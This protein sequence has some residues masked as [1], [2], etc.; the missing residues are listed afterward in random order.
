MKNMV[1]IKILPCNFTTF[2][3]FKTW[4]VWVKNELN[5]PSLEDFERLIRCMILCFLTFPLFSQNVSPLSNQRI[6]TLRGTDDSSMLRNSSDSSVL[7]QD[8]FTI[9]P[10]SV[11]IIDLQSNTQLDSTYFTVKNNQILKTKLFTFHSALFTIKYR[12]FPLDVSKKQQRL[13]STHINPLAPTLVEYGISDTTNNTIFDKGLEYNGNYTQGLSLGNAQNLVVNQNFN[14]NLAGRLGDMDIL[15]AMTDNNLPIQAEGN[16]SELREIDKI[17]IQLKRKNHT[18]IAGDYELKRPENTYFT[19]YF[20]KLQGVNYLNTS[21]FNVKKSLTTFQTATLLSKAGV[22]IAKGKFSRNILPVQEGNQGP[23][24]LLGNEGSGYFVI[25]S[26]TEKVYF[27]GKILTRGDEY[28]YVIDYNRGDIQFT[29]KRLVTKDSRII[30]EFE[31]ADQTYLRSTAFVS[32]GFKINKLRLNFNFYSEQDSKNSTGTQALD[33][34]DRAVLRR[35]G[36]DVNSNPP[37]SIRPS[38]DGF[39]VDRIQYKLV[40]TLVNGVRF[41]DVLVFSTNADSA[42]Y[43]AS[44]TPVGEGKGNYIQAT[45]IANGR[46]YE[47]VSPDA[48]GK[49]RGSFE[50]LKKLTPPNK[51]QLLTLGADYQLFKNTN[52]FTEIALSNN[53]RNRFSKIGDSTNRG[54]AFFTHLTNRIDFGKK[55][56]W[57]LQSHLK[58]EWT[59]KDFKTLNPYRTAEFTRDWNIP[60]S[61]NT[62]NNTTIGNLTQTPSQ[63]SEQFINGTTELSR[64]NWFSMVYD[65]SRYVRTGQY[66]GVKNALKTH[67]QRK[68]WSI[69]GEINELNTEGRIEKTSFSRPRFD[70]HKTFKNNLKLGVSVEREKNKRFDAQAD[71]LTR[72]SFYDDLWKVYIEKTDSFGQFLGLNFLQRFDYQPFNKQ[73][74]QISKVN[75]M[76]LNGGFT[77]NEKS[78]LLWNV[79]YRNLQVADTIKTNL[80]P[81]ETYLGRIEYIFNALKN[82]LN[83][84]TLYEIGSGQEQK[85]EYQYLKVNKGE[86]QYVWRNRNA[87]TIPQLDEFEN[88]PFQDQADYVR[89]TL[90]SNQFVRTNNIAFSQSLRFDPHTLWVEKQGILGFLGHF[91]TNSTLQISKRV[92]PSAPKGGTGVSAWNP[93]GLVA[94]NALVALNM[95]MRNSLFFNRSSPIWDIELG[96]LDNR[97]RG[98]FVTGFEERGRNELFLRS[99]WNVS[100]HIS[101][102]NYFAKGEQSNITEGFQNRN[103]SINLIKTEPELTWLLSNDVRLAFQ[104]KY[105]NALNTLKTKGET[106]KNQDFSTEVTWNQATNTQLRAKFSYVQVDFTGEKNT[107]IEFAL[108]EGL[109]NG[110]NLLWNFSLDRIL[111]KNMFLNINYEGRKTGLVRVVHVGRVAVRANF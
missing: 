102:Q 110:R 6:F 4:N 34:L 27:D 23:Y 99:R 33:S 48:N 5:F 21:D 100:S 111:S 39:K 18:L 73:F 65:V 104:Y 16:T 43:T 91:S 72:T 36:N 8:T 76:N 54:F 68:G 62:Q 92:A 64:N 26:G 3:V 108:L 88:A 75:E 46:V 41:K 22:G 32:N 58:T 29:P 98:I 86:G 31:Y 11:Q 12:V 70:A 74:Q 17:F 60:L 38:D 1:R 55:Q 40:D 14:L 61:I 45:T 52:I 20:K 109:Q 42:K 80:K 81:Q 2:Q 57:S 67:F 97:N 44:F 19:S 77:K 63:T 90:F 35:S 79:T 87:D 66:Q 85:L 15:A 59:Q 105:K 69:L 84:N 28:D 101:L 10:N 89:V 94:D 71:T 9:I 82:A 51:Q 83:G 30:V 103:Y 49:M 106:L 13:D 107:P 37:L 7:L 24:R 93:F 53:D 50:P 78:Q 96:Q 56:A 47:W 25:L 95:S